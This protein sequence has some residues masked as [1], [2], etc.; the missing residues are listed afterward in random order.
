MAIR[1]TEPAG[2]KPS[3]RQYQS[4]LRRRSVTLSAIWQ[5]CVPAGWFVMEGQP[6]AEPIPP[7]SAF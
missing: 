3:A 6:A 1:R 2:S 5:R 4:M 7:P